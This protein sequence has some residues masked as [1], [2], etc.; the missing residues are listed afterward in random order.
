MK[1]LIA[2]C[3]RFGDC[4]LSKEDG[5]WVFTLFSC[6]CRFPSVS[7]EHTSGACVNH[8]QRGLKKDATLVPKKESGFSFLGVKGFLRRSG[9]NDHRPLLHSWVHEAGAGN[10][11]RKLIWPI[12]FRSNFDFRR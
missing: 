9:R 3:K 11:G 8:F 4:F 12:S 10:F 7:L 1:H 6:Y 5:G 2:A